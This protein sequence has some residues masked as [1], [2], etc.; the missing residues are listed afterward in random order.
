MPT[1]AVVPTDYAAI[2]SLVAAQNDMRQMAGSAPNAALRDFMNQVDLLGRGA[3][4]QASS[5]IQSWVIELL[6]LMVN[7][8]TSSMPVIKEVTPIPPIV[9]AVY[10]CTCFGTWWYN[11]GDSQ[12]GFEQFPPG[13][14]S[15]SWVPPSQ[16]PVWTESV[17]AVLK[18]IDGLG[19]ML[20]EIQI[21]RASCRERV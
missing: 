4:P 12:Y 17:G 9:T 10:V 5:Q 21:G 1:N 18:A 2:P 11:E 19:G 15:N 14:A 7:T 13:T 8:K 20:Y 16:P 3:W 6:T